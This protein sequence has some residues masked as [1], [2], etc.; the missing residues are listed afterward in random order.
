MFKNNSSGLYMSLFI[1]NMIKLYEE[2]GKAQTTFLEKF[3][4]HNILVHVKAI[5]QNK[6]SIIKINLERSALRFN[7]FYLAVFKHQ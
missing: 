3:N 1:E 7:L 5:P 2:S 6:K 4:A